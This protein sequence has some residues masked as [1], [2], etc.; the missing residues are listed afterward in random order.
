MKRLSFKLI[1]PLTGLTVVA[2][3]L[4]GAGVASAAS[5]PKPTPAQREA[6]YE[7][8]LIQATAHNKLTSAQEAAVLAEHN[9]LMAELQAAP[10]GSARQAERQVVRQEAKAWSQSNGIKLRFLLPL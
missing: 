9:H 2:T 3:T 7:H 6:R 5:H 1:V 8:R 4:T 10:A